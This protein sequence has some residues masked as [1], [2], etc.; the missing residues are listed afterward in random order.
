MGLNVV[1]PSGLDRTGMLIQDVALPGYLSEWM[2]SRKV[3]ASFN[4]T[5]GE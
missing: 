1:Q 3:R 2:A 4:A 5:L